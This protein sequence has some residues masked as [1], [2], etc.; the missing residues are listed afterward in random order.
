MQWKAYLRL[1]MLR[2]LLA[3]LAIATGLAAVSAPAQAALYQGLSA[4]LEQGEKAGETKR[5][6]CECQERQ[7]AQRLRGEKPTPCDTAKPLR[8]YIPTVQFGADRA[9]E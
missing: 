6:E 4:Q 8:I 7:R 9:Y 3:C 5:A 2:R 1:A